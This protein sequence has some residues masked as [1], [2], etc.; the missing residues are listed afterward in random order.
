MNV[1]PATSKYTA[2]HSGKKYYFCCGQCADKFLTRPQAYLNKPAAGLVTLG[3]PAVAPAHPL[4]TLGGPTK[5]AAFATM[6]RDP[7]C[8]MN[9]NPASAKH[10]QEHAGKKYYFCSA[11]CVEKFKASPENYLSV[12]PAS[13][14]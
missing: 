6:E 12:K 4:V 1:D 5:P 13:I 11:G 3:M 9:V 2:E 7:V 10:V 8:G 14:P